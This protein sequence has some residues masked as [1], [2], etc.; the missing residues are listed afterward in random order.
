MLIFKVSADLQ[1]WFLIK[2]VSRPEL[3]VNS[4]SVQAFACMSVTA[5]VTSKGCWLWIQH[6]NK[7]LCFCWYAQSSSFKS[8]ESR[9]AQI[10][11]GSLTP[12]H[13]WWGGVGPHQPRVVSRDE[14]MNKNTFWFVLMYWECFLFSLE[15]NVVES[16]SRGN[17]GAGILMLLRHFR[18]WHVASC[19]PKPLSS[20]Q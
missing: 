18:L 16:L 7:P 15:M 12:S 5:R 13:R 3:C 8:R 11:C 1:I 9:N 10:I 6:H 20:M 4:T 17:T 14:I 2:C 19:T